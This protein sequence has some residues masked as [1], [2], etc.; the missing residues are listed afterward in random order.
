MKNTIAE[1]VF[2]MKG[3]FGSIYSI[4]SAGKNQIISGSGDKNIVKWSLVS[5]QHENFSVALPYPV[6]SLAMDE[7]GNFLYAGNGAGQIHKINLEQKREEKCLQLSKAILFD[8]LFLED[9]RILI[10]ASADGLIH[11]IETTGGNLLWATK[12]SDNKVRQL[13]RLNDEGDFVA[14]TGDGR[15]IGI[16]L[17]GKII[18]QVK[19][20]SESCNTI[21]PIEEK[22]LIYTGGK[23]AHLNVYELSSLKLLA[24]IPAHN[25][26]IYDLALHPE[27]KYLATASRDKT[28]KIWDPM[29]AGFLLRIE[30]PESG[31]H[32]HSVNRLHWSKKDNLLI[33][34]G[35]DRVLVARKI[36]QEETLG[37]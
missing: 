32:S 20:H 17:A 31:G 14:A 21:L 36:Y 5:G 6:Y 26:A 10:S 34:G 24:S 16:S 37:N 23:D 11:A 33:S 15:F 25:F 18:F 1:T 2:R 28:V 35:D 30:N 27:K 19:A 22:N 8:L 4:V 13:R 12:I 3:H 29:N 7:D 9:K